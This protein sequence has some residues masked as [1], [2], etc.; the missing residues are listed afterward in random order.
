[1]EHMLLVWFVCRNIL[2]VPIFWLYNLKYILTSHVHIGVGL[3][4]LLI[5]SLKY[6]GSIVSND[7]Y[8][9]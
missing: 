7:N 4:T 9:D 1:M 2:F 8:F 3:P 6:L 5:M